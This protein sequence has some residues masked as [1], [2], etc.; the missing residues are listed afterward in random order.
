MPRFFADEIGETIIISGDDAFHISRSL[1]MK[2]GDEIIICDKK[3]YDY[4]CV[5]ESFPDNSVVCRTIKKEPCL[6]E[7]CVNLTIFQA[8]PKADKF[9]TIIQKSVEL[10]VCKIVPVISARCVSRPDEKSFAKKLERYS[11]ISL[12][13]AKQSGRGIIPEI[14]GIISF[15][16]ALEEMKASDIAL[17]CYEKGGERLQNAGILPGKSISVMVGSEGGF[18]EDEIELAKKEGIIPV[19]L[20]KRILRC[21]TAPIAAAAVIMNIAGDI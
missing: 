1:R 9:E 18:E 3:G 12:E 6:S 5:I 21:E 13:A 16:K 17:I 4:T 7:P 11:K 10:G 8:F 2:K 19:G 14:C 15:K 20:G